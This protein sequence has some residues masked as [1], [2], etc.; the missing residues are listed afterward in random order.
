VPVEIEGMEFTGFAGFDIARLPNL[1][2]SGRVAW[3][4]AR[5]DLVFLAPFNNFVGLDNECY[6]WLCVVNLLTTAV[7]ALADFEFDGTGRERFSKFIEKYFSPDF[8][9]GVLKLDDPIKHI[10]VTP[11]EHL[12]QFFR[13]GLAHSFCIEWGGLLHR[14]DGATDYLF[15]RE[16]MPGQKSLGIVPR[17]LVKDFLSA[18]DKFFKESASWSPGSA[19]A[20]KFDSHFREI[21]LICG[22][23]PPSP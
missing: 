17:E 15:E 6:V 13:C 9:K 8:R 12:Y 2:Y 16:P 1:T 14:E 7:E 22:A 21:F 20:M 10:A 4:R 18:V 5:F 23:P 19:E 11:A 3:L